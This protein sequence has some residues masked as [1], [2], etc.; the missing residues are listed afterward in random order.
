MDVYCRKISSIAKSLFLQ[1][2]FG[3][4]NICDKWQEIR[5]SNQTTKKDK[6]SE[7]SQTILTGNKVG[8][9]IN[10]ETII[11]IIADLKFLK[12]SRNSK[13][14]LLL[15]TSL[16]ILISIWRY[17][18]IYYPEL[19]SLAPIPVKVK[20]TSNPWLAG[21]P[22]GST[23]GR[24]QSRV[25]KGTDINIYDE[26]PKASPRKVDIPL[27]AGRFLI[28]TRAEGLVA[29][30]DSRFSPEGKVDSIMNLEQD[31]YS[32]GEINGLS[33]VT[34]PARSLIGV[35][36]GAEPPDKSS[37]PHSLFFDT[38]ESRNYEELKPK[39]KQAFFIGDGQNDKRIKQKVFVPNGATSLFLGTMDSCFW[40]D[41]GGSF[42]VD[43]AISR[44]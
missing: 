10:V 28:F 15:G 8:R 21:M 19:L 36:L 9:D 23:A 34:A 29:M 25:W 4:I 3:L 40:T 5:M 43:V 22:N 42:N 20:G 31:Q 24:C 39:L 33:S 11:Q 41:N 14:I 12:I 35:F 18:W 37:A 32:P 17:I 2:N 30:G 1:K 6:K 44:W 38:L 26:A 27:K 16:L 13:I 7:S